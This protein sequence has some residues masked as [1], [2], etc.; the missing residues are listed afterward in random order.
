MYDIRI[1]R[2][3]GCNKIT[4]LRP[5]VCRDHRNVRRRPRYRQ[6]PRGFF[7]VGSSFGYIRGTGRAYPG[8]ISRQIC[9]LKKTES[10][11][12]IY[13]PQLSDM[14]ATP[15]RMQCLHSEQREVRLEGDSQSIFKVHDETEHNTLSLSHWLLIQQSVN[16]DRQYWTGLHCVLCRCCSSSALLVD[17]A[18]LP[19]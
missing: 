4:H 5:R 15:S 3:R 17:A 8:A 19:R 18:A 6:L 11:Y 9:R 2:F 14:K 12:N 10:S 16:H 7:P 1:K 13:K